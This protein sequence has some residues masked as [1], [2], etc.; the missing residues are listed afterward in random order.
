[1]HLFACSFLLLSTAD[2]TVRIDRC[3]ERLN[4]QP[5]PIYHC[6]LLSNAGQSAP[7]A[8]EFISSDNAATVIQSHLEVF[9]RHVCIVNNGK[10]DFPP[11]LVT[12]V[13]CALINSCLISFNNCSPATYVKRCYKLLTGSL[14]E[15]TVASFNVHII[16]IAHTFKVV[17]NKLKTVENDKTKRKLGIRYAFQSCATHEPYMKLRLCTK[18]YILCCVRPRIRTMWN[19]VFR[20]CFMLPVELNGHLKTYCHVHNNEDGVQLDSDVESL[21]V[22]RSL[23]EQSPLTD[24]FKD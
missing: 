21:D 22:R 14:P 15:A 18:R 2:R 9:N 17:A 10:P 19:E 7:P 13:S 16:C 24:F 23:K 8:F 12:D 5:K 11:C 20:A 4:D 3:K 6:T 1:M